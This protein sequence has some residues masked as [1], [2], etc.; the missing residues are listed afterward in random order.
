MSM[1]T[2]I[3]GWLTKKTLSTALWVGIPL[4]LVVQ[5]G[6]GCGS[7][8][9]PVSQVFDY[10]AIAASLP[11]KD[12]IPLDTIAATEDLQKIIPSEIIEFA[13][14]H[15]SLFAKYLANRYAVSNGYVEKIER[16][17]LDSRISNSD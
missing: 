17:N 13:K 2:Y 3:T 10:T 1:S 4:F 14:D 15:S 9:A 12:T 7:K 11:M 5:C 6:R 8:P 16:S